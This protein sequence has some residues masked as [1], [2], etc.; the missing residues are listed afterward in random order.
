MKIFVASALAL[1]SMSVAA[2]TRYYDNIVMRQNG[3]VVYQNKATDVT[4]DEPLSVGAG[5]CVCR[6][7][8]RTTGQDIVQRCRWA[9]PSRRG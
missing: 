3:A 5:A 1:L 4:H 2:Q 9:T 8:R 7:C 6:A